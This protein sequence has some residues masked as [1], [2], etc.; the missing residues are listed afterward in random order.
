MN[1]S[2]AQETEDIS[3]HSRPLAVSRLLQMRQTEAA[4]L[5][6]DSWP[7][8]WIIVVTGRGVCCHSHACFKPTCRRY[9]KLTFLPDNNSFDQSAVGPSNLKPS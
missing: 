8:Q 3:V 9:R 5:G 4:R 1:A 6:L 2:G 7:G